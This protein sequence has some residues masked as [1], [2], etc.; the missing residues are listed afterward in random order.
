MENG[1]IRIRTA[2]DSVA[3]ERVVLATGFRPE[4]PGGRLVDRLIRDF[5][6]PC[7]PCGYPIVGEDLLWGENIY[8]TGPLA[9][10]QVGPC[11]RNIVGARN[12][13]RMLLAGLSST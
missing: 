13:G 4:R 11:A 1:V 6:L 3:A 12:A 2:A 7:N 10:L 5:D 9:E 8:V